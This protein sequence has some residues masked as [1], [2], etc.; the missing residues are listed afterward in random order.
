MKSVKYLIIGNSAAG[1]NAAEAIRS[2]DISGSIAIVS[3]ENYRVYSRPLI[4]YFLCN[5][6]DE[7][8]M[9]YRDKDFYY[10]NN[11]ELIAG[12][13]A[14][15]LN[16]KKKSVKLQNE[17]IRFDRLLIATGSKPIIP[18]IG[19]IAHG[20]FTFLTWDDA[21]KVKEFINEK[22]ARNAVVVGAGLI[23]LKATEALVE[24]GIK[25]TLVELADR[26]L[27]ST[28]DR[29]ASSIIEN[30]LKKYGC[31]IITNDTIK[32]ILYRSKVVEKIMLRSGKT[33]KTDM[34]I[35]A[36]GVIPNLDIVHNTPIKTDRGILVDE[37]MQTNI[38]DVYAAGDV[39]QASDR[40]L[41]KVRTIAI[42]PNACKQGRIAGL[43]MA[44]I[45]KLYDG[46]FA[47]NSVELCGIPT[48]SMGLTEPPDNTF[49]VMSEYDKDSS[50]YR[51]VVLKDNIV[52]GTIFVNKIDRA[53]I[54][55]GL[56]KD[57]VDTGNFR[58]CLL[59]DDFGL[60]YLP[61]EYRKHLVTGPG[62][63]V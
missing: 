21:K 46:S 10:R 62:I 40:I 6:V 42:W 58:D 38:Q 32:N 56:I 51:K 34:V 53:G 17:T 31:S 36:I 45:E 61:K 50:A 19:K 48:I 30:A 11:I 16:V 57:R 15:E 37:H 55:W 24:L 22:K 63:E 20:V 39:V 9:Y 13:R 5:R 54:F 35:L 27:S 25:V 60:I 7:N 59:S 26:I 52:V 28:F 18:N 3:D 8:R 4:S 43:N 2:V 47:M 44:G 12:I 41:G 33:L 1:T 23:G 29:N 49:Q 14:M